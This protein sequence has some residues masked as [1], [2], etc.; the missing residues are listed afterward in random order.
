MATGCIHIGTM[1]G[2]LNGVMPATTPRG[3]LIE[4]TS[5][6]PD[7]WSEY[8]PLS[9]CGSPHAN[10]TTSR[11]RWTSPNAS[12]T[13]LPCSSE[14][15]SASSRA[16]ASTS[17]R[18]ANITLARLVSEVSPQLSKA[19]VAAATAVATS[20]VLARTTSACCWPVAGL[21]TGLRRDDVPLVVSL[22]IQ[23]STVRIVLTSPRSAARMD[24]LAR[25]GRAERRLL[26][27][28]DRGGPERAASVGPACAARR[29]CAP[30]P[31][32]LARRPPRRE[33]P[34]TTA[35]TGR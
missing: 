24:R 6:P 10:S 9:R 15:T 5:M 3:S 21:K 30:G 14:M 26:A 19:A 27:G 7:T 23:C 31:S 12:E 25:R 33:R 1:I 18:K 29:S 4:N 11:P 28:A 22:L 13:T 34:T 20:S 16:R 35:T 32:I 2:K 17:C 8:S